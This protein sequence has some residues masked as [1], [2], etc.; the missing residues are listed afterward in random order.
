MCKMRKPEI[1]WISKVI[2]ALVL[3]ILLTAVPAFADN[4][5]V[6]A[7]G[8]YGQ[9]AA[10]GM[11]AMINEFRTGSEAWYWNSSNTAKEQATNLKELTY[12]Y[13]LEKLAMQRAAEIA[14]SYS[15]T[16]TTG[17]VCSS[18]DYG[19]PYAWGENIAACRSSSTDV[20]SC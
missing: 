19:M 3:G 5:T 6:E 4:Y 14:F 2:C 17:S 15:H 7:E 18:E 10:R 9:T 12:D 20:T 1:A 8:T 11:L 13:H 16:R